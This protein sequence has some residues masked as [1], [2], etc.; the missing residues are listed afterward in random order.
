MENQ[1]PNMPPG[2]QLVPTGYWKRLW[3]LW[4]ALIIKVVISYGAMLVAEIIY[5]SL[6][7]YNDPNKILELAQNQ[8]AIW[9]MS[10]E[11]VNALMP[12]TTLIEGAAAAV[13]IP[14][15]FLMFRAD[16]KKEKQVGF[17][18][19]IKAP[20]IKY[21]TIILISIAMC[22][23]VN[24]ILYIS[25][26]TVIDDSYVQ[27]TE[28]LYSADFLV[29]IICLGILIPVVEELVF[30]GMMY[31]RLRYGMPYLP[32]A[33]YGSI[34]FGIFHGNLVQMIYAFVLGMLF[35][36]LYEKYGSVKAPIL[37]HVVMNLVSVCATDIQLMNWMSAEYVR[38]GTITVVCAAVASSMFVLVQRMGND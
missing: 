33:L 37:A 19:A 28:A 1:Q 20:F 30:R 2:V 7:A 16:C 3:Y 14:I 5:L 8:E 26:L 35:T 24:N 13:T 15:L 38:I 6:Y 9:D 12:Y 34:A 27:V 32:A 11:I 23:G 31:K 29:Q 10:I 22:V 17:P 25:G 21:G 4:G 36:Y 18:Q